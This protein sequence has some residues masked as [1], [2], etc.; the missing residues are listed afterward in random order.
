MQHK[1]HIY[2]ANY[3][4]AVECALKHDLDQDDWKY[5]WEPNELNGVIT[6]IVWLVGDYFNRDDI[7]EYLDFVQQ[8]EDIF[9]VRIE[10]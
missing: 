7:N 3:M 5:L 9:Q 4:Q 10:S 1:I 8:R 6:P 2:S